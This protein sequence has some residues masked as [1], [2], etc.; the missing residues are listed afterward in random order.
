[1]GRACGGQAAP[2]LASLSLSAGSGFLDG[3]VCFSAAA[4]AAAAAPLG[5][6]ETAPDCCEGR[7]A[8]RRRSPPPS[9]PGEP[10]PLQPAG[11]VRCSGMMRSPATRCSSTAAPEVVDGLWEAQPAP[12]SEQQR[13][14]HGHD[15]WHA[16]S[17]H[18]T[19]A[20]V[21]HREPP[22]LRA[23][24]L[25]VQFSPIEVRM[26]GRSDGASHVAASTTPAS[27][28]GCCGAASSCVPS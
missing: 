28:A 25:P 12:N 19:K 7:G 13:G 10:A 9:L 22:G 21:A 11:G 3:D 16:N 4:G 8:A 17:A 18:P 2:A 24:S 6:G 23:S 1:M 5:E 15:A 14:M 27:R 26:Q 20:A